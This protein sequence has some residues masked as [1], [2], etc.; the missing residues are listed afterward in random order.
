MTAAAKNTFGATLKFGTAGGSLTAV[1]ELTSI[2]PP[3]F[4]REAIEATTHDS[5]SGTAEYIPD[6]VLETGEI[7]MEGLL[8]AG[9]TDDDRIV[10][11]MVAGTLLDWEI[12]IKAAT[13]TKS[14][15]GSDAFL[16]E[17]A[18]GDMPVKGGKQTFSGTLKVNGPIAVAA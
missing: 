14:W 1:A 8:I 5:A 10:A 17:Y 18:V 6:G 2:T 11:A 7:K 12:E 15:T 13:G 4:S 9:S 16:T 3:T